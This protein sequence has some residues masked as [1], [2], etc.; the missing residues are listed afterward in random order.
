MPGALMSDGGHAALLALLARQ[1]RSAEMEE[2]DASGATTR[3]VRQGADGARRLEAARVLQPAGAHRPRRRVIWGGII[4]IGSHTKTL[5]MRV[6]TR[7]A[8]AL[9]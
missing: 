2:M 3:R 4:R 5:A 6:R 1:V 9:I 7:I 8:N